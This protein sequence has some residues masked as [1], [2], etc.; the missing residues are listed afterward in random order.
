MCP[1]QGTFLNAGTSES[2]YAPIVGVPEY[3]EVRRELSTAGFR[4]AATRY[5]EASFGSWF[6]VIDQQPRLRIVW[7]GKDGWLI[8]Q[9]ADG[10]GGWDVVW[11]A[12]HEDEQTPTALIREIELLSR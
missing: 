3:E 6:V 11:V 10:A 5:D 8:L 9:R 2:D 12:R 4:E 7:D 1:A